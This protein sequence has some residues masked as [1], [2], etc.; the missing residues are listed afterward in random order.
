MEKDNHTLKI[1]NINSFEPLEELIPEDYNR[2]CSTIVNKDYNDTIM[3]ILLSINNH[4]E[5]IPNEDDYPYFKINQKIKFIPKLNT[6]S[7]I[8]SERQ[9]KDLHLSIPYYQRYKNLKLMY[10]TTKHGTAMKTFYD[11]CSYN[12]VSIIVI[13][14][15]EQHIFGGYLSEPIKRSDKFYG[16]GESF[17]FTFHNSERIHCFEGTTENEYYI[18]SD[19]DLFAMGC[20]DDAFSIAVRDDFLRGSSR[21]TKTYKNTV[22]AGKEEFFVIKFEVWAFDE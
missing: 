5:E 3:T 22:L 19:D 18:Y 13:K 6:P 8:L 14:D 7:E 12:S 15:D 1:S 20:S 10:S 4:A 17:V 9:L 16:T 11:L 21:I 2:L